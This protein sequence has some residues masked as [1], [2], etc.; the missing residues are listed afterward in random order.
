M[1]ARGELEHV[2]LGIVAKFGP[3]TAY[4]VR[5]HFADSPTPAF[6]SSAGTIYP[7]IARLVRARLLTAKKVARGAQK[8]AQLTITAAGRHAHIAWLF[9]PRSNFLRPPPDPLRTRVYFLGLLPAR[10]RRAFLARALA[11]LTAQIDELE[12]YARSWPAEGATRY[13]RLA[14]D[15]LTEL[16]RARHR[17]LAKVQAELAAD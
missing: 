12:R 5:R 6:S 17:W 9:D 15:G 7:A 16:A 1:A 8:R 11:Q 10:E 2:I 14:S 3:L 4:A 13:S